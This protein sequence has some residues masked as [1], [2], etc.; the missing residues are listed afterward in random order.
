MISDIFMVPA[1]LR[2][3]IDTT[4]RNLY[5]CGAAAFPGLT[6]F[7][8]RRRGGSG[9]GP[10]TSTPPRTPGVPSASDR[11]SRFTGPWSA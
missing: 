10:Q 7:A 6:P 5:F 1:I 9:C 11:R 8:R 2:P 3:G 4:A